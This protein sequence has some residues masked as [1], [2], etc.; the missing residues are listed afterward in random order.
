VAFLDH[1]L[2]A[3][4]F[5]LAVKMRHPVLADHLPDLSV[6]PG[7][8]FVWSGDIMVQNHHHAVRVPD[9]IYVIGH[10]FQC[11]REKALMTHDPVNRERLQN[12][13]P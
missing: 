12:P 6:H 13:R 2:V 1:H 11:S 10:Q 7:H 3:D 8:A 4:P 9:A 5:P